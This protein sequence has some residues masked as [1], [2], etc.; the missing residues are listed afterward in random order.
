MWCDITRLWLPT[1]RHPSRGL[2][3]THVEGGCALCTGSWCGTGNGPGVRSGQEVRNTALPV[4]LTDRQYQTGTCLLWET[5]S[6]ANASLS[7]CCHCSARL[8]LCLWCQLNTGSGIT[9]S[10]AAAAQGAQAQV[11]YSRFVYQT[12]WQGGHRCVVVHE[13]AATEVT[14]A[15]QCS[16]RQEGMA[17]AHCSCAACCCVESPAWC[18][19]AGV[20]CC[21][22]HAPCPAVPS[23]PQQANHLTAAQVGVNL[24]HNQR[25]RAHTSQHKHS[26][27]MACSANCDLC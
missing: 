9:A 23:T 7:C 8:H 6:P 12:N 21:D 14:Q 27:H 17:H 15:L 11:Y 13:S 26:Q 18:S 16:V 2:C 25:L 4:S 24:H 22:D 20:C 3:V 10:S 19:P 5:I 1:S